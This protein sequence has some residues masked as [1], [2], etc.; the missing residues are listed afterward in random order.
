LKLPCQCLQD[1]PAQQQQQQHE[2][3]MH[4]TPAQQQQQ[5]QPPS[6]PSSLLPHTTATHP[7]RTRGARTWAGRS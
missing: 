7:S 1:T 3:V 6:T 2:G 5:Q 4:D